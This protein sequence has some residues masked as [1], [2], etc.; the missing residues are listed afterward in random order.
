MLVRTP[1][2]PL[3]STLCTDKL[4]T[5]M[6]KHARYIYLEY[7][8]MSI[9]QI[10]PNNPEKRPKLSPCYKTLVITSTV[11]LYGTNVPKNYNLISKNMEGIYTLI[12]TK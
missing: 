8:H 10:T 7:H 4:K 6:Q 9:F 12:F 5:H 3:H 11:S 1:I 2:V